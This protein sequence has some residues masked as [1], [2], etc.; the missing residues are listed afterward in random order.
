MMMQNQP[1]DFWAEPAREVF[2]YWISFSPVAP[3]FGVEWRFAGASAE[4]VAEGRKA[5]DAVAGATERLA[6]VAGE[7]AE[8]VSVE[9]PAEIEAETRVIEENS[10]DEAVEEPV[11]P[12]LPAGLYADA[13]AE[14]DDLTSL[15]GVGPALARKLNGLG[16]YTFAQL[17]GFSEAD[18]TWLDEN[19]GGI[20]GRCFRDNW[21]GQA[22][23]RLG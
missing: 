2:N 14:V 3:F 19:L 22:K 18:L 15:N 23:A 4:L 8:T 5:V 7:V 13:P 6:E 9:I 11:A 12:G 17:A 20:K 21:V 10:A 1:L 16:V